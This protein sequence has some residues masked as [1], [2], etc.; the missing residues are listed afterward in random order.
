[1]SR[2]LPNNGPGLQPSLMSGQDLGKNQ[3]KIEDRADKTKLGSSKQISD[4]I[5]Q[6]KK[7]EEKK[8]D[9][10]P[11]SS[12]EDPLQKN[13]TEQDSQNQLD[14]KDKETNMLV[15]AEF[16]RLISESSNILRTCQALRIGEVHLPR[17]DKP[18]KITQTEKVRAFAYDAFATPPDIEKAKQHRVGSADLDRLETHDRSAVALS[19]VRL[20]P[21]FVLR[22]SDRLGSSQLQDRLGP[23][24]VLRFGVYLL[25]FFEVRLHID[26]GSACLDEHLQAHR[27]H[28]RRILP[29]RPD[30]DHLQR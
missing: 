17:A 3:P 29:R 4:P 13:P 2:I 6:I 8:A 9:V 24:H 10:Q 19:G 5:V 26:I 30:P 25:L 7:V 28:S 14:V 15:Q 20:W 21:V 1:M 23:A 11:A 12:K 16:E 22:R 18:E 27:Q